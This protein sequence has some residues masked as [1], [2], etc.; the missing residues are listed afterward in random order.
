MHMLIDRNRAS[1]SV[2]LCSEKTVSRRAPSDCDIFA[3]AKKIK[4]NAETP[5]DEMG[6][7]RFCVF[8]SADRIARLTNSTHSTMNSNDPTNPTTDTT[9]QTIKEGAAQAW[10]TTKEK[11]GEVLHTGER[12]VRDNP[13]TSVLSVFGGGLLLGL[14]IGWSIAREEQDDY[15]DKT[16]KFFKRMGHKLNLD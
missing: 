7:K 3:L 11:A 8:K 4:R 1:G 5:R 2:Y 6:T 16:R 13:G 10:E 15:S 14:L 12:Y 9:P